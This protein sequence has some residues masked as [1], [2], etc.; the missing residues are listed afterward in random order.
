MCTYTTHLHICTCGREDT[1][2]ISEKLCTVAKSSGTGIFG[3]CL[4][5]VLSERDAT[6]YQCWQCKDRPTYQYP[7]RRRGTG[8]LGKKDKKQKQQQQVQEQPQYYYYGKGETR[9]GWV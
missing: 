6:R 2:L 3:S 7:S 4:D 8:G 1:V 5:G 9:V